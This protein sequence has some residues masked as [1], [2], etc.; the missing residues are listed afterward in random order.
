VAHAVKGGDG[1]EEGDVDGYGRCVAA[2]GGARGSAQ[3]VFVRRRRGEKG[4][5]RRRG[6]YACARG[7]ARGSAK[8][9]GGG[10]LR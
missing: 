5:R 10:T 4:M 7:G 6:C 9:S 8:R 2:L 3:R 1:E